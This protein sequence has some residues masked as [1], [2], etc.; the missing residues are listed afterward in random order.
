MPF[1][2]I[3]QYRQERDLEDHERPDPAGFEPVFM[4]DDAGARRLFG[5][6]EEALEAA[7]LAG[8]ADF[9]YEV[10]ELE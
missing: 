9:R 10:V 5:T 3:M 4:E 7:R 1:A 6:R 2:V 8:D